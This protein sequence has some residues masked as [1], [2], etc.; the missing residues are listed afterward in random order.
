MCAMLHVSSSVTILYHR[1]KV[2]ACGHFSSSPRDRARSIPAL[3]LAL[4]E[5]THT[6]FNLAP[7]SPEE[8]TDYGATSIRASSRVLL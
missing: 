1:Q 7:I 3:A 2:H 4:R 8:N 6:E 5:G